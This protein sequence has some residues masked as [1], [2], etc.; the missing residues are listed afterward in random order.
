MDI[1]QLIDVFVS[2]Y[3]DLIG[4][5][6]SLIS[7]IVALLTFL[8]AFL[9]YRNAKGWIGVH[10]D[11]NKVSSALSIRSEL[12]KIKSL[13]NEVEGFKSLSHKIIHVTNGQLDAIRYQTSHAKLNEDKIAIFN[14]FNPTI[15]LLAE[16]IRI[17][18]DA[19]ASVNYGI[20]GVKDG[21]V[22]S[23]DYINLVRNV[24][25]VNIQLNEVNK[26][27]SEALTELMIAQ[28]NVLTYDGASSLNDI[29]RQNSDG[30][31]RINE[32]LHNVLNIYSDGMENAIEETLDIKIIN[33][34]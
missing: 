13:R 33:I 7:I 11:K 14:C 19:S 15:G 23:N 18:R 24:E 21:V 5:F 16:L 22:N 4:V 29:K 1:L 10:F 28:S 34:L 17:L 20:L 27:L 6:F 3:K 9:V 30:L 12:F 25:R 31:M 8:I 2:K 32:C 26:K